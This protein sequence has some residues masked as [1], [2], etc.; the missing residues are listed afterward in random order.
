V[1]DSVGDG[2]LPQEDFSSATPAPQPPADGAAPSREVADRRERFVRFVDEQ[3][4]R[5]D[6]LGR[7]A[8]LEAL[9]DVVT[10]KLESARAGSRFPLLRLVGRAEPLTALECEALAREVTRLRQVLAPLSAE[11]VDATLPSDDMPA[12]PTAE[13]APERTNGTRTLADAFAWPL[14]VLEHI[15]RLGAASRRGARFEVGEAKE[16]AASVT[17]LK[18]Q[19]ARLA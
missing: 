18:I 11:S 17:P 19:D 2:H 8:A 10:R 4:G 5:N 1:K 7:V 12:P 14:F 15:A 3:S 16:F 13:P 6:L 9:A